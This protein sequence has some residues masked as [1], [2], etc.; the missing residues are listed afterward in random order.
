MAGT[1]AVA[2]VAAMA[3]VTATSASF[4]DVANLDLASAGIGNDEAFDIGLVK[5]GVLHQAEGGGVVWMVDLSDG[6][7]PGTVVTAVVPVVNNGPY[8]ADISLSV[9]DVRDEAVAG[10][11]DPFA[12]YRWTI[13]DD[14]TGEVLAGNAQAP[15]ASAVDAAA[16]TDA[17]GS[18][19]LA[20][21]DGAP[22]TDGGPWTDGAD[23]SCRTLRVT[24]AY[25]DTAATEAYNGGSSRMRLAFVAE[26]S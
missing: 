22:V 8:A 6:L 25:P 14:E 20:A 24:V 3:F 15:L 21:R 10:G 18:F 13:V 11:L 7:V 16:V 19:P 5:D 2:G 1:G 26:S 4:Q 17:V 12:F 23:G 9:Q